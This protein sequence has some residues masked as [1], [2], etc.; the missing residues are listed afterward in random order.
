[1]SG[2]RTAM[3]CGLR[4]R[5]WPRWIGSMPSWRGSESDGITF[6][7]VC[8]AAHRT[9]PAGRPADRAWQGS[10]CRR[11][12]CSCAC[13]SG[14][15]GLRRRAA[16]RSAP[17]ECCIVGAEGQLW[18]SRW[19]W[20]LT[21]RFRTRA[22]S[23]TAPRGYSS[24]ANSQGEQLPPY[25]AKIREERFPKRDHNGQGWWPR[26]GRRSGPDARLPFC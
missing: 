20:L 23:V 16:V 24:W 15:R 8:R 1:M 25:A 21:F 2:S 4:R 11:G 14:V 7:R 9:R 5:V 19:E 10:R 13:Y 3:S 26:A 17:P 22:P 6:R 18:P 12:R